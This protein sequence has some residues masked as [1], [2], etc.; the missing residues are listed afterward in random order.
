MCLYCGTILVFT[1]SLRVRRA[2]LA[3][4]DKLDPE[5]LAL[6]QKIQKVL[7]DIP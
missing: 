2:A 7:R 6:L 4:L 1:K 5:V 3:E